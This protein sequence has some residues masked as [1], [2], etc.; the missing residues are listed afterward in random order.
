[1][2]HGSGIQPSRQDPVSTA[3][4]R[5][6]SVWA[7]LSLRVCLSRLGCT[8]GVRTWPMTVL[9]DSLRWQDTAKVMECDSAASGKAR[10]C[11]HLGCARF[12]RSAGV[13]AV[14]KPASVSRDAAV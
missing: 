6:L 10:S 5:L 14:T 12:L 3:E 7:C 13:R 2:Q 4:P 9:D 11:C 8:R 1:M